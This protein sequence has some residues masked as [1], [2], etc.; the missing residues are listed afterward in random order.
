MLRRFEN[1][2][3]KK[4]ESS[5]EDLRKRLISIKSSTKNLT[6]LAPNKSYTT[7]NASSLTPTSKPSAR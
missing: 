1:N 2:R 4:R 3:K 7:L 5:V 6:I